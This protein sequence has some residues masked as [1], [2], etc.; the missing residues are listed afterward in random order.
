[1]SNRIAQCLWLLLVLA[2]A[3]CGSSPD[4][5]PSCTDPDG[6]RYGQ[7]AGCLGAD[8]DEDDARCW[9]GL[10]CPVDCS[11]PDGDGYGQGGACLGADCDEGA[12]G[13]HAGACC[14]A[15]CEDLDGDGYG[16][17][18]GCAGPD[19]NDAGSGI[20][21]GAPEVC[22]TLDQ[23]CDGQTDEDGVCPGCT[24]PDGDGFGQGTGCLGPDCDEG[25]AG[26]SQG[27]CC[28]PAIPRLELWA[29]DLWAQPLPQGEAQLSLVWNGQPVEAS[30]WPRAVLLLRAPGTLEG[31]LAAPDHEELY[32]SVE[33][34]DPA[35]AGGVS[36][37]L[38]AGVR[39]A[40]LT[41]SYDLRLVDG[42]QT[43]VHSVYL[44]LRHA[45][46][47]AQGRPARRGNLAELLVNGE[48]AFGRL[49][50]DLVAAQGEV[51]LSSWW[52]MSDFELVRD[53]AT[54]AD[55]T[56]AER[57]AN[58][59]LGVLE[60][61]P[62]TVRI[63]VGEFW[64]SHDV[65]DWLTTDSTLLAYAE[66]AGDGIEFMGQGNASFGEFAWDPSDFVFGDRV[67]GAFPETAGR[68]FEAEQPTASRLPAAW[69]DM[70]DWPFIDLEVELASWHQK[71]SVVDHQ[72]AYVGGMNIKSTDWD[73]PQHLVFEH[74]RMEFDATSAE[75]HAVMAKERLPDLGP[76]RDYILRLEGPAAQDAAEVFQARWRQ[77]R[78][79]GVTYAENTTDFEVERA[80]PERAGGI[81]LQVTATMPQPFWEH[82][83]AETWFNA[84]VQAERYILI[85]DQYW[86]IPL[87][88]DAIARRMREQP[89]LLLVVVTKAIDEWT[90]PGCEWT[91]TTHQ[92]L[93]GEFGPTRYRTYQLRSFDTSPSAQAGEV[94][95]NFVDIDT[96]SK[97]LV[98]DD[99]F[100]SVGSC[101]K[102]NRG[103]LY[104]GELN[105]AALDEPLTRGARRRV[106][107]DWL[108]AG[109]T[110]S[111]DTATWFAQLVAAADWNAAVR[112]RW[113]ALGDSADLGGG[114][115]PADLTPAGLLYPLPFG[116]PDDC[117]LEGVGP[118]MTREELPPVVG[119]WTGGAGRGAVRAGGAGSRPAPAR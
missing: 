18:A 44:G 48:E 117:F 51:L 16:L 9:T 5:E 69:V 41:S 115:L 63:L 106:V 100:L 30:G 97:L 17:G 37:S 50:Q 86:R 85:E 67:R 96:H 58:T 101:N 23:D 47:S 3:A 68:A 4:P 65:M 61:L 8:C 54:H 99:R 107:G 94:A 89:G 70:T 92:Q 87:L 111:E 22:D 112:A 72:V 116:V 40:G 75:R 119:T 10:C 90:D 102:N 118:D 12:P 60:R 71:F 46:F 79:D 32:F 38:D 1:M 83:I 66:T 110:P 105:V 14:P 88:V 15:A 35:G 45:W 95:A 109:A 31:R 33:V 73:G 25:D 108:G 27:A 26:C 24:D 76:R 103:M 21:P 55:L 49:H 62:A 57:W 64:G 56:Q 84:V 78:A 52:W 7:G 113:E 19:C 11:D 93:L 36:A 53:A 28:G 2:A 114:A 43:P 80:I 39:D 82:A 74:R 91:Y 77:A 59:V 13:C 81:Q 29:L 104:E 42:Q 98:V 6:D 34:V 20:H